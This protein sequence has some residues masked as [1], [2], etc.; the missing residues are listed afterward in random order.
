M[1]DFITIV[2]NILEEQGKSITVLFDDNVIS[3]NTFYKYKQHNPSLKTILKIADYLKVSVDYMYELSDENN[4]LKYS[5]DQ[6][7]FYDKLVTLIDSA[8]ISCRKFCKDLN[9][10]KDNILRYKKGVEP[11]IQ[12]L[13]EIAEYFDC[14][15]DCLLS[16]E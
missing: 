9:Y 7:K 15:V 11:N 12:T 14:T 3:K 5:E 4:Y 10:A 13:L 16:R 6:S 8:G 2:K 1:I